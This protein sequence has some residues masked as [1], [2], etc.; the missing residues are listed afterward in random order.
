MEER[1]VNSSITLFYWI[2]TLSWLFGVDL[3][4][5][6]IIRPYVAAF[7]RRMAATSCITAQPKQ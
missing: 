4:G 3:Q 6:L 7:N 1:L 5:R 2:L